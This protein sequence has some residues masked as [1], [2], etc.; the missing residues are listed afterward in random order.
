M[1]FLI[2]TSWYCPYRSFSR[3]TCHWLD[4]YESLQS[5]GLAHCKSLGTL[6]TASIR[7]NSKCAML[8]F[9]STCIASIMRFV[10]SIEY[11]KDPDQ[12]YVAARVLYWTYVHI[13]CRCHSP[14]PFPNKVSHQVG[15]H[16]NLS[17]SSVLE[18]N[19]GIICGSATAFPDFFDASSPRSFGSLVGS[20]LATASASQ[21][22]LMPTPRSGKSADGTF[23]SSE[24]GSH[25]Q[26]KSRW[27]ILSR[28]SKQNMHVY[29]ETVQGQNT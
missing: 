24:E 3:C 16:L 9:F 14:T 15:H 29:N 18:A 19:I 6:L 2:F 28:P 8:I 1:W 27:G 11:A 7:H 5:L 20:L 25:N 23:R 21:T 12:T 10:I 4:A 13:L 22:S 26:L 17:P